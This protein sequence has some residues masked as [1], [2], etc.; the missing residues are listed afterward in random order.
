MDLSEYPMA[1]ID[2]LELP[3]GDAPGT[4]LVESVERLELAEGTRLW[5]AGEA[6]AMHKIRQHLFKVRGMPRSQ[7]TVRGYWKLRD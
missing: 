2:W 5:A 3:E 7:A 6:A 1:T 4:T